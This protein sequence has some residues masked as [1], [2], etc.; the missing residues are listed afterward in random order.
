MAESSPATGKIEFLQFHQ[1]ALKDGAYTIQVTQTLTAGDKIAADNV[2]QTAPKSFRVAGERYAL[3]P[4]DVRTVFPPENSGGDHS[5]V[6]P[7]IVLNRSTLPWERFAEEGDNETPWLALLVFNEDEIPRV[8]SSVVPFKQLGGSGKKAP[9]FPILKR[10]QEADDD[11]ISVIDVPW[12]LL[13]KLLPSKEELRLLAH[14]RQAR[15]EAGKLAGPET[16]VLVAN[17]LPE[18]GKMTTVHLVSVEGCLEKGAG[19]F[20]AAK[21]AA[22]A[23]KIRLVTLKSWRFSCEEHKGSFTKI[24]TALDLKPPYLRLPLEEGEIDPLLDL[25]GVPTP[26]SL[27]DGGRTVSIYRGPL[28]A[29]RTD[30]GSADQITLP[31]AA[32]DELLS[33]HQKYGIFDTGYAAAWE[34]GRLLTLR[35]NRVATEL[36]QWKRN[37]TRQLHRA[38]QV[39]AHPHLP[40]HQQEPPEAAE[41]QLPDIVENWFDDLRNLKGLPFN[42]LVPNE[43]MLPAESL[44]FFWVDPFWIGAL[45]DGAFSIGRVTSKDHNADRERGAMLQA[46][47]ARPVT[48]L[49]IRSEAVSGWPDLLVN[50]YDA[51][52]SD[53]APH[54]EG[55]LGLRLER[56]SAE[57]LI[58]LFDGEARTID[59]HQKPET[60]HFGLNI[61][62]ERHT[63]YYKKLRNTAGEE[64]GLEVSDIP[65]RGGD[66]VSRVIDVGAFAGEITKALP[67]ETPPPNPN[68]PQPAPPAFT[69][70]QFALEMI[71]GVQNVRFTLG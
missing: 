8:E 32:S 11:R 14:V 44:R 5:M 4:V 50:G 46:L 53:D 67:G 36:F 21:K 45:L 40:G 22:P 12:E 24:V 2:F 16:A 13:Q 69:S 29:Y 38:E 18:P 30:A 15:D 39:L 65:W 54:P 49:L 60:L 52:I 19:S 64:A 33:Y 6:I 63:G 62:D 55:K 10:E 17:R 71:E 47:W 56:L 37:H 28:V 27:R 66:P 9:R 48:G 23:D 57:V 58:W 34:L 42:Y 70:A 59:I 43:A 25:G 61:P 1:P 51:V 35:R 26:H 20:Y 68:H 7:H 31:A 3:N 41:L